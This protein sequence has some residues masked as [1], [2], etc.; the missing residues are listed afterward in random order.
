[1]KQLVIMAA[2]ATMTMLSACQMPN[3][4]KPACMP[5][6]HDAKVVDGLS[7]ALDAPQRELVRGQ[8]LSVTVTAKNVSK[9]VIEIVAGNGAP[10]QVSV[11]RRTAAGLEVVKTFPEN[12]AQVAMKWSL[13]PGAER[14]FPLTLPMSLDLPTGEPLRLTA[15]LNGRPDVA[16]GGWVEIRLDTTACQPV[17]SAPAAK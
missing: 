14:K 12:V 9:K 8:A 1:M 4:T 2:V 6:I 13:A 10:V 17:T 7:V 15:Q 3:S 11:A 16:P 5:G